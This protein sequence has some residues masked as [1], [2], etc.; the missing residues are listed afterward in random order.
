MIYE[1]QLNK[2]AKHDMM[3]VMRH[4]VPVAVTCSPGHSILVSNKMIRIAVI[5]SN[6]HL[7]KSKADLS[8]I[9][10]S[11]GT[12][13]STAGTQY[14]RNMQRLAKICNHTNQEW[15]SFVNHLCPHTAHTSQILVKMIS[16]KHFSRSNFNPKFKAHSYENCY[17]ICRKSAI[18]TT[19]QSPIQSVLKWLPPKLDQSQAMFRS[20][21]SCPL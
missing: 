16:L 17:W 8:S 11:P 2:T 20:R 15:G 19:E 10:P 1:I 6:C 21:Q 5:R 12:S 18:Q 13:T 4:R 14:T 9:S 7:K 3:P